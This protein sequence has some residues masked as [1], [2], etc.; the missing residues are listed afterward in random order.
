MD[1][2]EIDAMELS[3]PRGDVGVTGEVGW[4]EVVEVGEARSV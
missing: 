4:L 1:W 2:D 3:N